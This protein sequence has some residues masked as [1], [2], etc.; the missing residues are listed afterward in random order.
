LNG[1]LKTA[2]KVQ[3]CKNCYPHFNIARKLAKAITQAMLDD[4]IEID[5][6]DDRELLIDEDFELTF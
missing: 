5:E 4:Y 3:D 2:L 1:G 6:E